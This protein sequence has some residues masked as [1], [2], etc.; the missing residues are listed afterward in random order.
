MA[1]SVIS[2]AS[3]A[4]LVTSVPART[5]NNVRDTSAFTKDEVRKVVAMAGVTERHV[6]EPGTCSTDL[7]AA[8]AETLLAA[9]GWAR[10]SV[11]ALIFVT[12]TPDYIMPSSSCVLQQRL[13]LATHCAAFDLGLGCSGYP[14]GLWLASMMIQAGG[15]RRVLLLHGE[16]PTLYASEG[17]R[18]VSLLF[19]DAGSATAI[20][21]AEGDVEPWSFVLHTD[22]GGYQDLI[23]E[24]GR[25]P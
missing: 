16:T 22:G 12:Q 24:G 11:D 15:L 9:T 7:C 6:V 4:G 8:A 25:I 21:K 10:D 17:D 3:L 2:G 23:V 14:Y 1:Q 18:S 13:G 5:V 20:Q 19:G